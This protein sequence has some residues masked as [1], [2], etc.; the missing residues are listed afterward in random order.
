MTAP[1]LADEVL[2]LGPEVADRARRRYPELYRAAVTSR[3]TLEAILQARLIRAKDSPDRE[4]RPERYRENWW[5]SQYLEGRLRQ[6]FEEQFGRITG[7]YWCT[8]IQGGGLVTD[9]GYVLSSVN[10]HDEELMTIEVLL[11]QLARDAQGAFTWDPVRT[12]ARAQESRHANLAEIS[13]MLFSA[14]TRVLHTADVRADPASTAADR[15]A[16]INATR[17]EWRL[18]QHR[19]AVLI[20][21]QARLEYF[22]GV[23]IGAPFAVALFALLGV[24]AANLWPDA[25][26]PSSFVAATVCGALG[27][28]VSVTQRMATGRLK[29]DYTASAW[30]KG[31]LGAWRPFLGGTLG[32]VLQFAIIGGLLTVQGREPTPDSPATFAFYALVGFAGGFSERL[33]TDLLERAGQLISPTRTPEQSVEEPGV[34][35]ALP[36]LVSEGKSATSTAAAT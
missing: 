4:N 13:A 29:I 23:L 8:K 12:S 35:T 15:T 16:A 9:R 10:M 31:V 25:V 24:S 11:K 22:L 19:T 30:A 5:V 7:T 33:A 2:Q 27:A 36:L 17:A 14:L 21:R 1:E 34:P 18:A 28:V 26:S 6:S 20:Q 32:G 3:G